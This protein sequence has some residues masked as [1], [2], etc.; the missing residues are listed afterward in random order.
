MSATI[1]VVFFNT[2]IDQT[3]QINRAIRQKKSH[4]LLI[5]FKGNGNYELVKISIAWAN[6]Q[7]VMLYEKDEENLIDD[8]KAR[9]KEVI[10]DVIDSPKRT[11]L[12]I[13][14][15]N[16]VTKGLVQALESIA[17]HGEAFDMYSKEEIDSLVG[18]FRIRFG[19]NNGLT[20]SD[21]QYLEL[22]R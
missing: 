15:R 8:W 1:D 14:E 9:L 10:Q 4:T 21:S 16:I 17:A 20:L 3:L 7:G 12:H 19:Q 13:E 5:A 2:I 6:F 18:A 11:I 22:M